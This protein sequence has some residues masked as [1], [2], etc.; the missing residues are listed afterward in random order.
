MTVYGNISQTK[1]IEGGKKLAK[2]WSDAL[3]KFSSL[4]RVYTATGISMT[5]A[6]RAFNVDRF[7]LTA[8]LEF[9]HA[10][11]I[12][13]TV[14]SP[15]FITVY[16]SSCNI[17]GVDGAIRKILLN[18]AEPTPKMQKTNRYWY[19]SLSHD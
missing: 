18:K 11:Y 2:I 9:A 3:E 5:E 4:N 14:V 1:S 17:N 6:S 7:V 16:I 19:E 10:Q 12:R 13:V 15:S 8:A